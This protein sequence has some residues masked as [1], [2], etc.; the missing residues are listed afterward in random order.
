MLEKFL[1]FL[2]S[3]IKRAAANAFE[4][5]NALLGREKPVE[6]RAGADQEETGGDGSKQGKDL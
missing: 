3:R 4:G 5:A 1:T 6:Q 2:P